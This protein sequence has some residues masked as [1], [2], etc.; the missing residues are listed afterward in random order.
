MAY[1]VMHIA[2]RTMARATGTGWS[3]RRCESEFCAP[4]LG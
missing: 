3:L 4:G 1:Q 2:R